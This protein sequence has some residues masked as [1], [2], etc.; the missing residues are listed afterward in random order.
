[1]AV[2]HDR[3]F[4]AVAGKRGIA[5]YSASEKKWKLFGDRHQEQEIV[6][7]GLC[8]YKQLVVIVCHNQT[9]N[10][11]EVRSLVLIIFF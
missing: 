9:T 11:Y 4:I 3:D 10:K 6:C 2:T 5:V 8:W 7:H 1:M